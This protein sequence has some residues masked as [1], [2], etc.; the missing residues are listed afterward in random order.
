LYAEKSALYIAAE[1]K[2]EEVFNYLLGFCDLQ[3]AMIKS[4]AD[5]DAFHVAAAKGHLGTFR[6]FSS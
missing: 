6:F 4:K 5:M 1:N 2:S 3:T